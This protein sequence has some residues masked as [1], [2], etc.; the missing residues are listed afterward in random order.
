MIV[1]GLKVLVE[2]S[3]MKISMQAI[4]W[5]VFLGATP[6]EG[7]GKK[8]DLGEGDELHCKPSENLNS[9]AGTDHQSCPE[10]R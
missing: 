2:G 9:G 6:M 4:D 3:K 7:R 5:G 1:V 10:M 8:Q